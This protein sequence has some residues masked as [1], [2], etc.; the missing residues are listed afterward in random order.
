MFAQSSL[1]TESTVECHLRTQT[2]LAP[3]ELETI[4]S[5]ILENTHLPSA[6]PWKCSVARGRRYASSQELAKLWEWGGSDSWINRLSTSWLEHLMSI[7][8]RITIRSTSGI[9]VYVAFEWN[10]GLKVTYWA[11]KLYNVFVPCWPLINHHQLKT[12]IFWN[13]KTATKC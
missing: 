13:G 11:S 4:N 12:C 5:F 7:S 9:L 3:H 8:K 1:H 6:E 10:C 2:P